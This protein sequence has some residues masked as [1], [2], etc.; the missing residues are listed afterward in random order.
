[1]VRA[2]AGWR[3]R[4]LEG[5]AI[6]NGGFWGNGGKGGWESG[7]EVL[8]AWRERERDR[9]DEREREGGRESRREMPR[10]GRGVGK[11]VSRG[12]TK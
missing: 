10:I 5:L 1:M 9:G 6:E 4:P 3:A 8:W 7:V 12:Q 2:L 11:L